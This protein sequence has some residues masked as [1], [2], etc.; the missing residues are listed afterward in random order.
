MIFIPELTQAIASSIVLTFQGWPPLLWLWARGPLAASCCGPLPT[1]G[2]IVLFY[3]LLLNDFLDDI[4]P[5]GIPG[6]KSRATVLTPVIG[7]LVT[8]QK[9]LTANR[10]SSLW[11]LEGDLPRARTLMRVRPETSSP[12]AWGCS[13]DRPFR[14]KVTSSWEL[15]V[16]AAYAVLHCADKD[17]G[18]SLVFSVF[19]SSSH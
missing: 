14:K 18:C 10:F 19:C 5:S 7:C 15:Q 2:C 4:A 9:D 3:F 8:L 13:G 12:C 16:S 1:T 6:S 17:T 11:S